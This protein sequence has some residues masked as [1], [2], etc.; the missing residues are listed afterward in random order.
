MHCGLWAKFDRTLTLR[1]PFWLR[2]D[3]ADAFAR[4]NVADAIGRYGPKAEA[5]VPALLRTLATNHAAGTALKAIN[6]EGAARAG[7]K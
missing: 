4:E 5:A 6:P 3:D 2:L 1:F 7:V